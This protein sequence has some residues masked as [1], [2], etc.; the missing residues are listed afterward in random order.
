MAWSP[1]WAQIEN[2]KCLQ[3]GFATDRSQGEGGPHSQCLNFAYLLY[4]FHQT[5]MIQGLH[6]H[7]MDSNDKLKAQFPDLAPCHRIL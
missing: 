2:S 1:S 6:L 4:E 7:C 3:F 5:Q